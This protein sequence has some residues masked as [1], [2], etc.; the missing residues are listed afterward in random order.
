MNIDEQI[1]GINI[2]IGALI[3]LQVGVFISIIKEINHIYCILHL[4]DKQNNTNF[5]GMNPKEPEKSV[6]KN[7]NTEEKENDIDVINN[8]LARYAIPP[9]NTRWECYDEP[10]PN[11]DEE[12]DD[13]EDEQEDDEQE[14]DDEQEED[15]QEDYNTKEHRDPD[16]WYG[17]HNGQ[18]RYKGEW[19]N[20]KPNGNGIKEIFEGKCR[21]ENGEMCND[22]GEPT[23]YSIIECEFVNGYAEGYGKQYYDQ[24]IDKGETSIPFYAGN[25][26]KGLQHGHGTHYF[27]CG[28]YLKG[29]F[30]KGKI[31]GRAIYYDCE[32]KKTRIGK[33]KNDVR[34]S[35]VEVDGELLC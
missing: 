20:G 10:E 30:K 27:G 3:L 6:E 25:F 13:Q 23:S 33:Y 7:K 16:T 8:E 11:N 32:T 5:I 14:D 29:N 15:D 18:A 28:C 17:L 31:H 35:Y 21:N 9:S 24:E 34:I 1:F 2:A 26:N 19:K 4:M 12:D 22:V